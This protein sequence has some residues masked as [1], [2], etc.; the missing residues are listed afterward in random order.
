LIDLKNT[1]EYTFMANAGELT[2]R[3]LIH[4]LKATG[5][6]ESSGIPGFSIYA[7]NNVVYVNSPDVANAVIEVY[8]LTGQRI[9]ASEK[10][11]EGLQQIS[12]DVPA[13]WY[14]V[15]VMVPQGMVSRKVYI[16]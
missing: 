14:I 8:N 1:A 15:K 4:F 12:M 5:I 3:F 6:S 10:K 11:M 16:Y 2:E 13:S 9:I 7:Y